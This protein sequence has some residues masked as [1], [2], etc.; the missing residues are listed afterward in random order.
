MHIIKISPQSFKI[1]LSKHDLEE[2]GDENPFNTTRYTGEFFEDI[3][4][5]TNALYDNPFIGGTVDAEFF[6]S[7][8]GGGELFL[9]LRH[10]KTVSYIF[11]TDDT[12]VLISLCKRLV[13]N[14]IIC[15]ST[16]YFHDGNYRLLLG[17]DSPD[18]ITVA[19]IREYGN[20]PSASDYEKW[21]LDEHAKVLCSEKAVEKIANAFM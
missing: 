16:L 4:Q 9:S 19:L 17:L 2:Y 18:T 5:R 1:I 6:E 8:D 12:E 10:E 11:S 13:S 3:I 7:K 21:L 14:G 20:M 15:Q